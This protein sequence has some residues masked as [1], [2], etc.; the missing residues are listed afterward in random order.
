MEAQDYLQQLWCDENMWD[1]YWWSSHR[2]SILLWFLPT[3]M[4]DKIL[5]FQCMFHYLKDRIFMAHTHSLQGFL[6][7]TGLIKMPIKKDGKNTP[8]ILRILKQDG[9]HQP[10][11]E[12][13][14]ELL[15]QFPEALEKHLINNSQVHG[16]GGN[17]L[18]VSLASW[19]SPSAGFPFLSWLASLWLEIDS[20]SWTK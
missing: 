5:N 16:G 9:L 4:I 6:M 11:Q 8:H 7:V 10:R 19:L 3:N 12:Q 14:L 18:L 2:H 17:W 13:G 1:L 20:S 15:P